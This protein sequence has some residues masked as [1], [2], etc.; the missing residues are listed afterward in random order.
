MVQENEKMCNITTNAQY[1]I[2]QVFSSLTFVSEHFGCFGKKSNG[3]DWYSR[4]ENLLNYRRA[5][6]L[7]SRLDYVNG[8]LGLT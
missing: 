6:L 7:L 3:D 1:M 4:V 2:H 5:V 8:I